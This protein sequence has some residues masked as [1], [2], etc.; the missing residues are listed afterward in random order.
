MHKL[1]I[2]T[3]TL[4]T[5]KWLEEL[6]AVIGGFIDISPQVEWVIVC[7]KDQESGLRS[8]FGGIANIVQQGSKM[9]MYAAINDG[10][11]EKKNPWTWFT[12]INDDDLLTQDFLEYAIC[13]IES[14]NA[15][16]VAYGDVFLVDEESHPIERLPRMPYPKMHARC[17]SA[18]RTPFTQQGT[19]VS[20]SAYIKVGGFTDS[21]RYAGD[22]D[23]WCHILMSGCSFRYY[24]SNIAAFRVRSGQ[25]SGDRV[26]FEEEKRNIREIYSCLLYT[27]DAAD[28]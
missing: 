25:L 14:E 11:R 10:L 15:E 4:G 26:L 18:Q 9:G 22:M 19:I 23:F 12:Y 8:K 3:P 7:P 24:P 27:S 21:L 5:S 28:E 1:R 16:D 13:H 6:A 17:W 20:K 2:V